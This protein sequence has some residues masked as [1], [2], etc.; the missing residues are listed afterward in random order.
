MAEEEGKPPVP[1]YE[2]IELASIDLHPVTAGGEANGENAR[3]FHATPSGSINIGCVNPEAS[4]Q[5]EIGKEYYI[6][7]TPVP[8]TP[9]SDASAA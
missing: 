5:F 4:A 1:V 6:D 8:A 7:F 3:F 9:T 2:E